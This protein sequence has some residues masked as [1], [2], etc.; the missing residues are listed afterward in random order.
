MTIVEHAHA[1]G[2]KLGLISVELTEEIRSWPPGSGEVLELMREIAQ[3]R[4]M[5]ALV[6][7]GNVS[8]GCGDLW[9]DVGRDRITS[10]RLRRFLLELEP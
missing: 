2:H 3:F 10:W 7:R 4:L 6:E 9:C 8:A 1:T 5:R